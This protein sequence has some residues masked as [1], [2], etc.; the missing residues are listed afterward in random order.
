ME[1]FP[2]LVYRWKPLTIFAK[3]LQKPVNWLA[4]QIKW[5]VSL[6]FNELIKD[7]WQGLNRLCANPTKSSNTR[8]VW[9]CFTIL[10]GLRLK[11]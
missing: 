1:L 2:N 6:A 3:R 4:E 11:G 10:W 7:I 9:V 8:I 5:L